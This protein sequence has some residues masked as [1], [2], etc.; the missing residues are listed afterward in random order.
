[1]RA[2]S[3]E[4]IIA[5]RQKYLQPLLEKELP[6]KLEKQI[7]EMDWSVLTMIDHKEQKRGSFSPLGA[8]EIDEIKSFREYL[9]EDEK[10]DNTIDNYIFSANLYNLYVSGLKG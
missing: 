10:S 1:M 4:K 6:E 3:R 2:E 7:D 5:T 9:M 8:M